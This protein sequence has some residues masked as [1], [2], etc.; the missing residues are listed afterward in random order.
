MHHSHILTE[1]IVSQLRHNHILT[2][3]NVSQQCV[4]IT[5][6]SYSEDY[7]LIHETYTGKLKSKHH[8]YITIILTHSFLL[9]TTPHNCPIY[10]TIANKCYLSA[11]LQLFTINFMAA[12][13]Q[14]LGIIG[15]MMSANLLYL[16]IC[17]N[18]SV[19][20]SAWQPTK[21]INQPVAV[22]LLYHNLTRGEILQISI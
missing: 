9:K 19:E 11:E 16:N 5:S 10:I 7:A 4:T 1:G 3:D 12:D 21:T 14:V 13:P 6:Q 8:N 15:V 18:C 22:R 20:A 2:E 17:N